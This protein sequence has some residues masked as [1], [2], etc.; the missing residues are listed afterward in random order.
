MTLSEWLKIEADASC[1]ETCERVLTRFRGI[2]DLDPDYTVQVGT[3]LWALLSTSPGEDAASL[4]GEMHSRAGALG[5]ERLDGLSSRLL[6][7]T[8]AKAEIECEA[9]KLVSS[10]F[11]TIGLCSS[12]DAHFGRAFHLARAYEK[13]FASLG[14][15][16]SRTD[17]S[18]HSDDE[19][20]AA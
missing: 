4:L 3:T 14:R 2:A 20:A 5:R 12:H 9:G 8:A 7:A 1:L 19:R 6:D 16:I 17:G 11:R 10:W 13:T 18:R 15:L